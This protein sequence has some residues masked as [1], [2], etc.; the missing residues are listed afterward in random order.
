MLEA[1]LQK[2][3]D[4]VNSL[5]PGGTCTMLSMQG[6]SFANTRIGVTEKIKRACTME[7]PDL[8]FALCCSEYPKPERRCPDRSLHP[9]LG[10]TFIHPSSSAYPW[11]QL[12]QR[13]PDF[14][15]PSNISGFLLGDPELV[16]GQRVD[17]IPP[18][19]PS[20]LQMIH[21]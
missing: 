10:C 21:K 17:V 4:N 1:D 13:A 20:G 9:S 2:T 11:K 8:A 15:V 3:R 5:T 16:Q 14:P 7:R 12:H 18:S 19:A 6:T